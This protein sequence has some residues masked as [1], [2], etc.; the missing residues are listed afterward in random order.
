MGV[1]HLLLDRSLVL[2]RNDSLPLLR[3]TSL[4]TLPS[5]L[6]GKKYTFRKRG[7]GQRSATRTLFLTRRASIWSLRTLVRVFSA[8]ALWMYSIKTRLFLKTLP[9]DF[10]YSEW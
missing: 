10:W 4:A 2:D 6:E 3:N 1:L 9:F 7:Q 8:F 5:S